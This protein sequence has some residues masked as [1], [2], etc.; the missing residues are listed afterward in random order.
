MVVRDNG[1]R[2]LLA[3]LTIMS[4]DMELLR[5]GGH[6]CSQEGSTESG[7]A[8]RVAYEAAVFSDRQRVVVHRQAVSQIRC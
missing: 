6:R 1:D 8:Y 3:I 4:I 7:A 5:D 2:L